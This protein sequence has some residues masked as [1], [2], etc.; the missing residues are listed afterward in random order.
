MFDGSPSFLQRKDA[1]AI[2]AMLF[3]LFLFFL[4]SVYQ[5][6]EARKIELQESE[7]VNTFIA[8]EEEQNI[9][10]AYIAK[11]SLPEVVLVTSGEQG[12]DYKKI[13]VDEAT[14]V[15]MKGGEK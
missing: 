9:L 6:A 10:L 2:L 3:A 1:L 5:M 7:L 13:A 11:S 4:F 14:L 8:L 15:T 12:L